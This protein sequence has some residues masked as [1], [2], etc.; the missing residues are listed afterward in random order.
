MPAIARRS[1][2]AAISA[3][4]SLAAADDLDGVQD[5]TK[6]FDVT[7]AERVVVVQHNNGTNGTVG[8]DVIAISKDGGTT[9]AVADKVLAMSSDDA[10]GTELNGIMN[11][12]GVEPVNYAAFK[13]GPYE[14]PTAIRIFRKTADI[15]GAATWVT[16]APSVDMFTVGRGAAA[17]TALA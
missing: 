12:A 4:V 8:V 1:N 7:G 17:P 14:G 6:S 16:G 11:A 15:A 10:T 2:M 3:S 5:N 9:W 13:C